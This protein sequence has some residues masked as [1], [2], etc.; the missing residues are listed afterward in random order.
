MTAM[1]NDAISRRAALR[2]F[3]HLGGVALLPSGGFAG[4][5][6]RGGPEFR[7][8]A[9]DLRLLEELERAATIFFQE[10]AHPETGLVMDRKLADG[11]PDTRTIGSI[12]ATG[13]GLS[14]LCLAHERQYAPRA[15]LKAQV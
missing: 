8:S 14:V 4:Q 13:F 11:E 2:R 7:P 3:A 6:E 15:E 10:A 9:A 5:A 1:P 12:A